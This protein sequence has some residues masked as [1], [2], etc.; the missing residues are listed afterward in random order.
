[1]YPNRASIGGFTY[2][3]WYQSSSQAYSSCCNNRNSYGEIAFFYPTSSSST[4]Y[5]TNDKVYN[6]VRAIRAF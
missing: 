1:M 2:N 3:D 6:Y 4:Q 5:A